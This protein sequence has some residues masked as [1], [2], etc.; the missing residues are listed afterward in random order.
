MKRDL[1]IKRAAASKNNRQKSEETEEECNVSKWDDEDRSIPYTSSHQNLALGQGS[2]INSTT[3][4]NSSEEKFLA[5]KKPD[6]S[7]AQ[8]LSKP[9]SLPPST[10]TFWENAG[11]L[12]E[13]K[14]LE[15]DF[16]NTFE[17]DPYSDEVY[18]ELVE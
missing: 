1:I 5:L 16:I 17:E 4:C 6:S 11:S 13:I 15:S 8:S 2:F 7:Y 3:N 18:E 12:A 9:G 10:M 14:K